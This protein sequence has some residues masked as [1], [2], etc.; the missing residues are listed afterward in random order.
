[1]P[2]AFAIQPYRAQG[3]AMAIEDA[4]VLGNLF[5]RLS[6]PSQIKPMLLAYESLRY[7]RT[8]STQAS[9]RLN[10][11]IF[12]LPDG[13]EQQAR[14]DDMRAAMDA[15][16]RMLDGEEVDMDYE[17]SANQWADR[18]KNKAQFAYDA[19]AVTERWW[20]EVGQHEIGRI[21]QVTS[22][23]PRL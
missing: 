11:R 8:A 5:S 14:D 22:L 20:E 19:D 12:H 3:A 21:G 6:H 10:Q 1:M 23:S 17:G 9:S 13:P 15:E 4:A 7:G 16:F 18:K 2:T